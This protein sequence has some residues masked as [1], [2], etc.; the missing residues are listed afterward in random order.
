[1]KTIAVGGTA[2]ALLQCNNGA[3]AFVGPQQHQV[4]QMH[5]RPQK[6][7]STC[8]SP[9]SR[10]LRLRS[11]QQQQQQKHRQAPV[12]QAADTNLEFF[13]PFLEKDFRLA[14]EEIKPYASL[15]VGSSDKI[16]NLFGLWTF[17]A[18]LLTGPIWAA[19]MY[20]LN[21]AYEADTDNQYLNKWDPNRAIYD[22]TGK[23][24]SR[25]WLALTM[26]TP[27]LSGDVDRLREGQGACLY[28]ANHASWLDIPVLCTVLD[29]VFKFIAKG[30][31]GKVPCIGQQLTGVSCCSFCRRKFLVH[32]T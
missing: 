6:L 3:S 27:T 28:V 22:G 2:F 17:V 30:E 26:S 32:T 31:L 13:K 18:S 14:D 24:W 29:P 4:Q 12:L 10:S 9:S 21:A 15:K 25:V 8:V 23:V 19:A 7:T 1:M 16:V 11:R 5:R 20:V